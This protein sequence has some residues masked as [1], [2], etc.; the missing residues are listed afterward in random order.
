MM[1][2]SGRYGLISLC[3]DR[4]APCAAS[5]R[6]G[7][8][9]TARARI[10]RLRRE[11]PAAHR[12]LRTRRRAGPT[13][14]RAGR[15]RRPASSPSCRRAGSARSSIAEERA[16]SSAAPS[17][18]RSPVCC[19]FCRRCRRARSRRGTPSRAVH[20]GPRIAGT[21]RRWSGDS[22]TACWPFRPRSSAAPRGPPWR[23]PASRRDR[24]RERHHLGLLVGEHV[25]PE[26]RAEGRQ[27]LADLL[28]PLL[29]R[30]IEPAPARRNIAW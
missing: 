27:P 6:S 21:V 13:P 10:C 4:S 20:G 14:L 1:L 7:A 19:R 16:R 18:R 3:R 28:Q 8:S 26:G 23:N 12:A 22:V 9:P 15:A 25:L 5:R 17:F 24:S 11:C 2:S 30:R 29:C